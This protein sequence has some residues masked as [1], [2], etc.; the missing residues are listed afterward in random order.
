MNSQQKHFFLVVA[1]V[2]FSKHFKKWGD[3]IVAVA[4]VVC[5]ITVGVACSLEYAKNRKL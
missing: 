2:V 5:Y 1:V 3:I 4:L